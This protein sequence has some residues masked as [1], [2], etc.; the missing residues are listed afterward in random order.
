MAVNKANILKALFLTALICL[1]GLPLSLRAQTGLLSPY[2]AFGAG[3]IQPYL[4]VRNMSMGGIAVGLSA[5]GDMNPFNPASYRTGVDTLSVRF[6]IGFNLGMNK[7][8]QKLDGKDLY[9]QSTSGGLSN[10]EFYFPVCKW[11]KMAIFLL[12]VTDMNYRSSSFSDSIPHIGQTQL[13]H[14]GDGGLSKVGW[15]HAF[16]WGPVSVG[17]NLAYMFGKLEQDA[18]LSYLDDSLASYAG[19]AKFYTETKLNGF[20]ADLGITYAARVHKDNY[21]TVGATYSFATTLYGKRTTMAQGVFSSN[22][23]TAFLPAAA[24]KGKVVFPSSVRAGISYEKRGQYV[25]GMDFAYTW[26]KDFKDYGKTYGYFE[27]TF[28][29]N[30]GAELKNDPQA[31]SKARK[32]AYRIGGFYQQQCVSYEGHRLQSFGISV[33]VGI[34]VRKSRSLINIGLQYGKTGSLNLGQIREDYMRI[35]VSFSSVE[36]WFVKPRYD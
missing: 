21:L 29:V 10:L 34:P 17:V 2:S 16:G 8:G 6:D 9:N 33:G 36:T 13:L 30:V 20:S 15:G 28:S 1:L 7:L 32:V 4:N 18:T 26:W 24:Q 3:T 23:D 22:T 11:Y 31:V 27:N 25:V 12:P 19:K 5:P 35:G 14:S